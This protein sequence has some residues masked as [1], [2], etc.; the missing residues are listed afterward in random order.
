MS[1]SHRREYVMWID[2]AKRPETRARRIAKAI[3]SLADQASW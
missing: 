1:H 2:D 3:A